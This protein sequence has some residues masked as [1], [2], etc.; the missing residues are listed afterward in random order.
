MSKPRKYPRF[1]LQS[2]RNVKLISCEGCGATLGG[3]CHV[4]TIQ[5]S[6]FRGDD[7]L[8]DSCKLCLKKSLAFWAEKSLQ[9][10]TRR[11]D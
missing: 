9:R 3:N 8:L 2:T 7:E 4:I 1:G 6:Y 11:E 5:Y 10:M